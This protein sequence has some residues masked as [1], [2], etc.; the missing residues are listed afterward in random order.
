MGIPTGE[1]WVGTLGVIGLMCRVFNTETSPPPQPL[2][3]FPSSADIAFNRP[4]GKAAVYGASGILDPSQVLPVLVDVGTENEGLR[5]DIFYLGD[6]QV[7]Q[8]PPALFIYTSLPR[9]P[10]PCLSLSGTRASGV[11]DTLS[12]W[13]R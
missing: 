6:R 1:G 12:S 5:S 7:G 2:V 3:L 10:F 4:S 13:T 11:Q 9:P 8:S